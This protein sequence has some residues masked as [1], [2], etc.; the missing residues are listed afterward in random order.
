LRSQGIG[1][2]L[3]DGALFDALFVLPLDDPVDIDAG[4]VD[5]VGVERAQ[6]NDLLHLDHADLA[7]GRGG[8]VEVPGGLAEDEVARRIGLPR[9]DDGQV[10]HDPGF[11]DVGP[12]VEFFTSLPSAMTV[13]TPVRV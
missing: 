11:E 3:A 1:L 2:L 13:P 10:G 9:L 7:A 12:A 6:G 8:R 4:Q 5:R